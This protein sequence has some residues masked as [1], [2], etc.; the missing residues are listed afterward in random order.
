MKK[1]TQPDK[2]WQVWFFP[3]VVMGLAILVALIIHHVKSSDPCRPE[4]YRIATD[5]TTFKTE[6][7]LWPFWLDR[8]TAPYQYLS[9][10][11]QSIDSDVAR[12]VAKRDFTPPK[13][14][15]VTPQLRHRFTNEPPQLTV[16]IHGGSFTN[17]YDNDGTWIHYGVRP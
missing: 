13:W 3:M 17:Y 11:Q 4:S 10:A 6:R 9:L 14:I 2:W 16:K 1:Q 12:A 7:R 8:D 5:G 15:T